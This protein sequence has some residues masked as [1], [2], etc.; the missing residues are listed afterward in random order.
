M[1]NDDCQMK[2]DPAP[3][4]LFVLSMDSGIIC[5]STIGEVL[6]QKN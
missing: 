3:A 2:N 4:E 1:Q 5:H 6:W